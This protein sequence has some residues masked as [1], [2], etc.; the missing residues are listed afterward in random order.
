MVGLKEVS[1]LINRMTAVKATLDME[2]NIHREA[3]DRILGVLKSMK[4]DKLKEVC[5]GCMNDLPSQ[6][7]HIGGCMSHAGDNKAVTGTDLLM[8]V[9]P[10]ELCTQLNLSLDLVERTLLEIWEKP[11]EI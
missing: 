6:I 5:V 9:N 2:A 4:L 11:D 1:I 8:T 7:D 3:K 10:E